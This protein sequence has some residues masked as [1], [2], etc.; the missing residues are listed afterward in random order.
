MND[1]SWTDR[2]ECPRS[3]NIPVLLLTLLFQ[4]VC[5]QCQETTPSCPPCASDEI[6]AVS[7]LSCDSCPLTYCV[8]S[9]IVSGIPSLSSASTQSTNSIAI[10][11][12]I[13]GVVGGISTL[14]GF[15]YLVW[16]C[17]LRPKRRRYMQKQRH[18]PTID[19]GQFFQLIEVSVDGKANSL[20]GRL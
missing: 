10:A 20:S 8:Q 5:V 13:L 16:R 9:S 11:A 14:L 6:C 15:A 19:F 1:S 3:T 2:S 12:I 17:H 18:E 7:I 4:G